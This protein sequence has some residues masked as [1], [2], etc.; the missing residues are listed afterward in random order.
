MNFIGKKIS[1]D[2]GLFT[3]IPLKVGGVKFIR[4]QYNKK[5]PVMKLI[6]IH[7]KSCSCATNNLCYLLQIYKGSNFGTKG[8]K[9]SGGGAQF[10]LCISQLLICE[11]VA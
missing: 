4:L 1:I 8:D 5:S 9:L 11:D 10:T 3:K 7:C 6:Q 2:I